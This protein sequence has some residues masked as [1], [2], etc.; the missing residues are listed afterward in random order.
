MDENYTALLADFVQAIREDRAPAVDGAEG[1]R[2][3]A[4]VLAIAEAARGGHPVLM[5]SLG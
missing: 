2:S 1:R 4:L 3:L 5:S